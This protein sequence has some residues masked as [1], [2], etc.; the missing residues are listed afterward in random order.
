MADAPALGAGGSNPMR[1]RVSPSAPFDSQPLRG[2][3]AHGLRAARSG[4]LW[5]FDESNGPHRLSSHTVYFSATA[6]PHVV[7]MHVP[8]RTVSLSVAIDL[9]LCQRTIRLL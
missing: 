4:H 1:V 7:Y 5:K 9:F 2:E 6:S 8:Y 3:L